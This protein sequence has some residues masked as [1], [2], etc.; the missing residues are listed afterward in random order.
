MD[1][2]EF[3]SNS[4]YLVFSFGSIFA[5]NVN[6]FD[7][8]FCLAVIPHAAMVDQQVK[9]QVHK[10]IAVVAAWSLRAAAS[11]VFPT[12]GPEGE[13]LTGQRAS[14]SG[15]PLGGN[16]RAT[17][18]GFRYDAKARKETNS[19]TRSYQHSFICEACLACKQHKNW[20]PTL[21]YKDFYSSA[22]WRMTFISA[23]HP[24]LG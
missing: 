15:K 4:E 9:I 24:C 7:S 10:K 19:F 8:K 21:T 18:F 23:L 13:P 20:D 17:Y 22:A 1:G 12:Q 16:F 11:G 3:Y 2:A 5:E 14:K 6:I